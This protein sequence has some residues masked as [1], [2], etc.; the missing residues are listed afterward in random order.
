MTRVLL[1]LLALG[2]AGCATTPPA[3]GPLP[4]DRWEARRA[5]LADL[6]HWTAIGKILIRSETQSWNGTLNWR[7]M[8]DRYRIRITAPLGQGSAQIVGGGGRVTL[9]TAE[10]RTYSARDPESLIFDTL[11]WRLPVSGLRYWMLG[12]EAPSPPARGRGLDSVGHLDHLD[13]SGWRIQYLRYEPVAS[14]TLP[15][16]LFLDRRQVSVRIVVNRWLVGDT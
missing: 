6:T 9:R 7:Q 10:N 5:E 1:A 14:H 15:G 8:G 11:G 3:P 16:K 13:Q 2:L 12:L 4:G